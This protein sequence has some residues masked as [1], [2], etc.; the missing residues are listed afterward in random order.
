MSSIGSGNLAVGLA[1][2][3][4]VGQRTDHAPAKAD[5]ARNGMDF[6]Q[7]AAV[8]GTSRD[9]DQSHMTEDRDADGRSAWMRHGEVAEEP[10]QD[11]DGAPDS[12][13]RPAD[14]H[15]R[16]GGRLDLHV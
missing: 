7:R 12:P 1:T 16:A 9:V 10:A 6:A 11:D 4:A 13:K 5:A 15:G 2:A 8:L 14:P 3:L